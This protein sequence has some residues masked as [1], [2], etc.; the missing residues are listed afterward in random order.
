[1]KKEYIALVTLVS[2]LLAV[3]YS[4]LDREDAWSFGQLFGGL[5][6]GAVFWFSLKSRVLPINTRIVYLLLTP[7][8]LVLALH[9]PGKPKVSAYS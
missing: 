2:V 5:A 3:G 1:M 8:L 6:I 7:M 9:V 4:A